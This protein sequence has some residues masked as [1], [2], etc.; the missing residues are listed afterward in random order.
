MKLETHEHMA[1]ILRTCVFVCVSYE[2]TYIRTLIRIAYIPP[3][4][5]RVFNEHKMRID[6]QRHRC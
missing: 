4:Y 2:N 5:S 6:R 3:P 1:N